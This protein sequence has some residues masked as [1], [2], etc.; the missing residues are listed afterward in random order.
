[1]SKLK[2]A[3][4]ATATVSESAAATTYLMADGML[5]FDAVAKLQ[6]KVAN[7]VKAAVKTDTP[8]KVLGTYVV[9]RRAKPVKYSASLAGKGDH[10]YLAAR[11]TKVALRK[12][13]T[14]ESLARVAV[15]L[16]VIND[17]KLNADLKAA[18]AAIARHIKKCEPV[19]GKVT[20]EKGKLRD[21][22][23]ATFGKSVAMLKTHLAAAGIKDT[24]IVESMGMMGMTVLVRLGKDNIVS[25]GKAD[26]T[27]FAAAVKAA[28]AGAP[29]P[30]AKAPVKKVAAKPVTRAKK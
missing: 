21:A 12:R 20:K 10:K 3:M 9:K 30:I 13:M 14:P 6:L 17:P 26:A 15:L 23:N 7:A 24:D 4:V 29:A 22:A 16:Q 2:I 28:K 25:V 1:M 11:A 19:L 5:N 18:G 27:R 8:A